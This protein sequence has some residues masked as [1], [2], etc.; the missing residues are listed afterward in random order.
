MIEPD[1]ATTFIFNPDD[2]IEN[3]VDEIKTEIIKANKEVPKSLGFRSP[4]LKA[5]QIIIQFDEAPRKPRT[6]YSVE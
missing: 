2:D 5:A 3:I 6:N 4:F 1:W